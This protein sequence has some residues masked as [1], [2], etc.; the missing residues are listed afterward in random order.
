MEALKQIWWGARL[1]WAE[2]RVKYF[3]RKLFIA[4]RNLRAIEHKE[5][6]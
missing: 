6:S 2:G 5:P 4:R 3:E 1:G